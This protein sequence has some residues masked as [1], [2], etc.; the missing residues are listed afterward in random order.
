MGENVFQ[1]GPAMTIKWFY[2]RTLLRCF[3]FSFKIDLM[4]VCVCVA[5]ESRFRDVEWLPFHGVVKYALDRLRL[6]PSFFIFPTAPSRAIAFGCCCRCLCVCV[7]IMCL[8]IVA[9]KM[10]NVFSRH[11]KS[12]E[13]CFIYIYINICYAWHQMWASEWANGRVSVYICV[14]CT[15]ICTY[16]NIRE[17]EPRSCVSFLVITL[18]DWFYEG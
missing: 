16:I 5:V 1:S 17:K 2:P 15:Y 4:C 10:M 3:C 14:Q 11:S 8:C 13:L 7:C 6:L 9:L 18:Y 12:T